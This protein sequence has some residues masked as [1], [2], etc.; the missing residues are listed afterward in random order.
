MGIFV[1]VYI[2][3][4]HRL[5]NCVWKLEKLLVVVVDVVISVEILT[6]HKFAVKLSDIYTE[7]FDWFIFLLLPFCLF[8]FNLN[9]IKSDYCF[10][11][12]HKIN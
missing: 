5:F 4:G 1:R 12:V 6:A 10:P 9:N 7:V 11:E 2:A 8:I 3:K